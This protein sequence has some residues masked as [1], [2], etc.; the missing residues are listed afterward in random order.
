MPKLGDATEVLNS[1]ST[2]SILIERGG[3]IKRVKANKMLGKLPYAAI[4]RFSYLV[5]CANPATTDNTLNAAKDTEANYTDWAVLMLPTTY[6]PSGD[7]VRLVIGCH[8]AGGTVTGSTSQ[9]E[10]YDIYKYLVANGYAVMDVSGLPNDFAVLKSI[11]KYRAMGSPFAVQS[12]VKAY[13]YIIDNFNIATDGVMLTGGSNGGMMSNAIYS[14][15]NIPI[16]AMAGMSPLVSM[17]DA[18]NLPSGAISGGLYPSYEP[19]A[20]II[21]IYGMTPV[22]THE[23]LLAKTIEADKVVGFDPINDNTVRDYSGNYCKTHLVP[24]KIWQPV[25]DPIISIATARIFIQRIKNA[26]CYAILREMASGGHA[27]ESAGTVIGTFTFNAATLNI[28]P[29]MHELKLW[30]DRWND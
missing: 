24:Y 30:F 29:A 15:G 13:N 28:Y 10:N 6:D 21:A 4:T 20:G 19:R 26:G 25:D 3:V 12:Y 14:H 1:D 9:T 11:D 23:E 27:P 2:D 17:T 22:S 16:R 5:N 8:G 18:W 7:P